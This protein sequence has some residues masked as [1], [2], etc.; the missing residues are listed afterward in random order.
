M[1][2]SRDGPPD[3]E[4]PTLPEL[5]A[6]TAEVPPAQAAKIIARARPAPLAPPA[7]PSSS[8]P[9]VVYSWSD[10]LAKTTRAARRAWC[11]AK[12]K[13]AN[14]PRLMSGRPANRITPDDV[15]AILEAARGRCSH[16]GSLAVEKR[17]S[18]PDG[19]SIVWESVGRRIGSLGHVISRFQGGPNTRENLAWSCLWCNTWPDERIH[20]A[21]DHGGHFPVEGLGAGRRWPRGGRCRTTT[22]RRRLSTVA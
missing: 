19:S 20:G 18:N 11:A 15:L 12:A 21:R 10:F 6:A 4:R 22:V 16:C 2:I 3:R 17:P 7:R 9:P 5:L 14:A 1:A 8:P 13:K